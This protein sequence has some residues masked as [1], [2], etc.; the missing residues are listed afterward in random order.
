VYPPWHSAKHAESW[1]C[2][3]HEGHWNKLVNGHVGAN[4]PPLPKARQG[5]RNLPLS[6]SHIAYAGGCI[7]AVVVRS[8]SVAFNRKSKMRSISCSLYGCNSLCEAARSGSYKCS[9]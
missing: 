8:T 7:F 4:K 6:S 3:F 1:Q 9:T 2:R 5:P